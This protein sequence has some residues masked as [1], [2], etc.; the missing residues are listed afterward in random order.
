MSREM[1]FLWGER[2]KGYSLLLSQQG[3]PGEQKKKAPS[4]TNFLDRLL[5]KIDLHAKIGKRACFS[6]GT[7]RESLQ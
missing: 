1:I 7:E 3:G 6:K 4:N 2:G 5:K